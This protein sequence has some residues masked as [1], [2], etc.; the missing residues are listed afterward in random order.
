MKAPVY[1]VIIQEV[2][3]EQG[4]NLSDSCYSPGLGTGVQSFVRANSFNS[5]SEVGTTASLSWGKS[6]RQKEGYQTSY[7]RPFS[8]N[9]T[10]EL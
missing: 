7:N 1:A 5:Q 6:G 2:S 8:S 4:Q 3:Q 9:H 10:S